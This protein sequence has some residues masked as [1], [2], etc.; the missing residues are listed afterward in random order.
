MVNFTLTFLKFVSNK[1]T[2]DLLYQL[3]NL[4]YSASFETWTKNL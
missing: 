3:I 4:Y 1:V 2:R